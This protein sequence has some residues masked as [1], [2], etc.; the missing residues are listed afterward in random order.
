MPWAE[1]RARRR[2]ASERRGRSLRAFWAA[3]TCAYLIPAADVLALTDYPYGADPKIPLVVLHTAIVASSHETRP[4]GRVSFEL[5]VTDRGTV[6]AADLFLT[7]QFPP[8]MR[9]VGKPAATL[10]PGCHGTVT[11]VCNLTSVRPRSGNA[12]IVRFLVQ[13]TQWSDQT[14]VAWAS[15]AGDSRSNL[16]SF[17]VSVGG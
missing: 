10:G 3:A 12:A 13:V 9:L 7:V 5:S 1:I 11:L 8:G 17:V 2:D 4:G 14:L 15:A 16:A 6:G